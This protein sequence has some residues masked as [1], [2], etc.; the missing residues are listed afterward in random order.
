MLTPEEI[1]RDIATYEAR[2]EN[3]A[4][5]SLHQIR[6]YQL[7]LGDAKQALAELLGAQTQKAPSP[8]P[9]PSPVQEGRAVEHQRTQ[10]ITKI[11]AGNQPPVT[12]S[13]PLTAHIEAAKD[14][15]PYNPTITI[16]WADGYSITVDE[17][18]ARG[19][20]VTTFRDTCALRNVQEGRFDRMWR[21]DSPWR[22]TGFYKA[23]TLFRNQQPPTLRDIGITVRND[24]AQRAFA[25]I[26]DKA[27]QENKRIIV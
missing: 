4:G 20:F 25:E 23:L 15:D 18:A 2:L 12:P 27:L 3:P 21:W 24:L 26:V 8:N 6:I 19:R 22:A 9:K 16:T 7:A 1:R 10:P 11:H 5:L 14:S 13:Q 17:T